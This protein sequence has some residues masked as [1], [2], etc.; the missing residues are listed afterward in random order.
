MLGSLSLGSWIAHGA[1]WVLVV[2]AAS[3]RAMRRAAICIVLW[4]V[5]YVVSMSI[6][7]GA[8]LFT[9]YVALLDIAMVLMVFKSDI[10]LT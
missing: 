5:G 8:M 9:S 7:Q 4:V 3:T 1:F 2:F 10:R 6:P